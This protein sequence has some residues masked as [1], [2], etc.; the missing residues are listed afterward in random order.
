MT[1]LTSAGLYGGLLAA[2]LAAPDL[3]A[4]CTPG[5]MTS[6][7]LTSLKA[8]KFALPDAAQRNRVALDLVECLGDP[9]PAVRDGMAYEGI[10][11]WL[12][13]KQ[14]DSATVV[15]LYTRLAQS[16]ASSGDQ[17]GF[18]K[19]FA[20]LVLSEVARADRI[21]PTFSPA[22]LDS[23]VSIAAAW[24]HDVD[25]YRG[26]V[27]GQGWRHGIAHGA[28]LVL[29]LALNPRI[30][31]AQLV[32]LMDATRTKVAPPGKA[33][34]V[35]TEG[36]RL[37]RAVF[38]S[39][40][41]GLLDDAWWKGWLGPVASPAPLANWN[42][43]WQSEAG[44]ARRHNTLEFLYSLHYFALSAGDDQGNALA[45]LARGAIDRVLGN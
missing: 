26:F 29:Q 16:L 9:D 2:L 44:L 5:G 23:L 7:Q 38:Y 28:D 4:A 19:P 22:Q 15:S 45:A 6:Q 1:S 39:H 13:G 18:R 35:H 30:S 36:E 10:S 20:V 41:R 40:R 11:T 33:V 24:M 25:D 14:L 21:T 31:A 27:D 8:A 12:R 37:A 3:Q 17:A 32:T 34:L 42:D 43:A